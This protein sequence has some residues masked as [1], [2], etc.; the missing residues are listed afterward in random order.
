[1]SRHL[2]VPRSAVARSG[3]VIAMCAALAGCGDGDDDETATSDTRP[4]IS[5]PSTLTTS[6]PILSENN[7]AKAA[8]RWEQVRVVTGNS[9]MDLGTVNIA[10]GAIQWR[11]K[12]SCETGNMRIT[13]TPPPVPNRPGPVVVESNCPGQGEGFG[14]QTGEVR[15]N[16]Q[17]SGPWKATLEQQVDSAL[18]EPPLPEMAGA[19]VLGRGDFYNVDKTG[20]GTAILYRLADGRR[21]LRIEPGFEVLNDP[22]LVVWVSSVPN[23]RTAKA[24]ADGPHAEIA[25][26]KSTRG[27]QNY[28]IPD[29][30]PFSDIRSVGLYCVPVPSIYAAAALS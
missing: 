3:A 8:P 22:D 20:K 16:V 1:M 27:S 21:A 17:A 2:A 13:S 19:E 29:D 15:V 23:P 9:P 12:W 24:M 14:R 18:D 6:P 4:S 26:L 25:A 10:D 28:P 30:L 5:F 7:P 11:V